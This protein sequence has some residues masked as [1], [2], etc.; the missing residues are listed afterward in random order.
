MAR[1]AATTPRAP[2]TH[3]LKNWRKVRGLTQQELGDR[4]DMDKGSI[5]RIESG[6][7]NLTED[8]IRA[9]S[10]ALDLVPGQLF[11]D[12]TAER[13]G[14]DLSGGA[15]LDELPDAVFRG[16]GVAGDPYAKYERADMKIPIIGQVQAGTFSEAY[17]LP[18]E[19][20]TYMSMPADSRFPG[21]PR[22]ALKNKGNSMNK[23]CRP[24][25]LWV[26]VR[27]MDLTGQGPAVGNYV[28]VECHRDGL[29]EA[30]A[31]RFELDKNGKPMLMPESDD[32]AFKP[33]SLTEMDGADPE[34]DSVV[35]V[36]RVLD[37]VNR[38]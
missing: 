11:V 1:K 30:T 6:S 15:Y 17:Q 28:I 7:T 23:V 21:I 19:D 12:P 14:A 18:E 29:V 10:K 24:G 35:V 13:T 20:W 3:F 34:Y 33:I 38:V 25:G 32:P 8:T 22:Y 27:Y 9:F 16:P 5:S 36:G 2:A 26:F 37:I 4:V 31:K